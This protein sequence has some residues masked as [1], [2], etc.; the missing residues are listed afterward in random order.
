[1]NCRQLREQLVKDMGHYELVQT[2]DGDALVDNGANRWLNEGIR[3]LSMRTT[4]PTDETRTKT[5]VAA[6]DYTFNV[7]GVRNLRRLWLSNPTTGE[8]TELQK[9][10]WPALRNFYGQQPVAIDAGTPECFC[11]NP[12]LGMTPPATAPVNQVFPSA[13]TRMAQWFRYTNSVYPV[14]T[15]KEKYTDDA[16]EPLSYW[17]ATEDGL[18]CAPTGVSA[19]GN[20]FS[21]GIGLMFRYVTE[22]MVPATLRLEYTYPDGYTPRLLQCSVTDAGHGLYTT[23]WTNDPILN[24]DGIP[25]GAPSESAATVDIPLPTE[26][27][28]HFIVFVIHGDASAITTDMRF[29]ISRCE[30]TADEP[31]TEDNFLLLPPADQAYTLEALGSVYAEALD[32]DNDIT[33]WTESHPSM[34]L[35]A[36]QMQYER[37]A[38]RNESGAQQFEP[39]LTQELLSI[40][41]ML[42]EEEMAGPSE[43]WRIGYER[44]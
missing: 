23:T 43:H 28:E 35:R 18:V 25:A 10:D 27:G 21:Y 39:S 12:R 16:T 36:A 24:R 7:P 13:S 29:T 30:V 19:D 26:L 40:R 37:M 1:M 32:S 8:S 5:G 44:P 2:V 11:R 15:Y 20:E 17:G 4:P 38:M 3:W 34:V 14:Y 6:G 33:W 42:A 22:T 31:I 41:F 9:G